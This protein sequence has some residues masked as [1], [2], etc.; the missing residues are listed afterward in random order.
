MIG[1]VLALFCPG[2]SHANDI[3]IPEVGI[4]MTGLPS[5]ASKSRGGERLD[6]YGV[7]VLF[8]D[9]LLNIYRVEDPVLPK[10]SVTDAAYRES[11]NADFNDN[12]DS[13]AHGE[14]TSIAGH[15][16]WTVISAHLC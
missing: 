12:L 3:D 1:L 5:S 8:G 13:N 16:A 2:A 6:G 4:R 11:L 10:A 15:T 7:G 9:V 14:A